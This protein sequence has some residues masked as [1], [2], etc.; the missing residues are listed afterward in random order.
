MSFNWYRRWGVI[1]HDFFLL[2]LEVHCMLSINKTA[3]RTWFWQNFHF[4]ENMFGNIHMAKRRTY[5]ISSNLLNILGKSIVSTY[6]YWVMPCDVNDNE[7]SRNH[8]FFSHFFSRTF[9]S[10]NEFNILTSQIVTS[11][12]REN[13]SKHYC[14]R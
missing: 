4:D 7:F 2:F 10:G 14:G 1:T 5:H 13:I 12:S 9:R 3:F 6:V 8:Y 11:S